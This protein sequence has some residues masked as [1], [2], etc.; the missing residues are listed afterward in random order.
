MSI[1]DKRTV[2]SVIIRG[3]TY[4]LRRYKNLIY[5][6]LTFKKSAHDLP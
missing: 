5:F 1:F 6:M 3:A 2:E 4:T